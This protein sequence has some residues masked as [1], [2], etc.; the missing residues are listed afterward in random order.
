MGKIYLCLLCYFVV[1]TTV[2]SQKAAVKSNIL[3]DATGTFNIGGE[4][5]I[6]KTYSVN[7]S[8]NF[9]GWALKPP[10]AWKHYLVQPEF[11]YWLRETFNEH[12]V[13]AHLLY[14][15]FDVERMSLPFFGFERKYLYVDGVGYGAGLS[16]G[17]QLYLTP[18]FNIEFSIG[19]GY[20]HLKYYKFDYKSGSE[21][22][23]IPEGHQTYH[24]VNGLY[25]DKGAVDSNNRPINPL[26][27]SYIGPTQIG[28]T[29]VYIIN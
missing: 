15:G 10:Q 12:Y 13:G 5:A 2:Y 19:L 25:Y 8:A 9:N 23:K 18:H 14:T 6:N 11:R 22:N 29:L 17:Y 1:T 26:M 7:L 3:Y 27:R 16:Y 24:S 28:V 21:A 20:L 4:Y